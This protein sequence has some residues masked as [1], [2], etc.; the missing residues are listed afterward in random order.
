MGKHSWA[1]IQAVLS[2]APTDPVRLDSQRHCWQVIDGHF[3]GL[4][5][6]RRMLVLLGEDETV[7]REAMY[8]KFIECDL[9]PVVTS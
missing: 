6:Q 9:G 5:E 1:V 4:Q 3:S 7:V 8:K 2:T